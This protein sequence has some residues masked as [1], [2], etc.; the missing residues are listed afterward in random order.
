MSD[1]S[2]PVSEEMRQRVRKAAADLNYAPNPL[3]RSLKGQASH[4][5][6]VMVGNSADPYFAEITRGVEEVAGERGYLVIVCNSDRDPSRELHYLRLLHDYRADGV[7]FASSGFNDTTYTTR[8]EALV[9]QMTQRGTHVVTL[10]QSL[11]RAHSVQPDNFNGARLM[12]ADLVRMGHTR[13][14]FIGGSSNLISANMHLQGYMTAMLEAG[15]TIDPMLIL[16]GDFTQNGGKLAAQALLRLPPDQRPTAIFAAND[17]MAYG[18]LDTLREAGLRAPDD[19][20]ICGFND[21]PMSHMID[22]PLTTVRVPLRELGRAGTQL[23]L[24]L[25]NKEEQ[26]M[27]R[28]LPTE[29]IHRKSVAEV[30]GGRPF[31]AG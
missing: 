12:T 14:A 16:S 1:S 18:A 29:V 17:E 27:L 19:M 4:L 28:V 31:V 13:I 10:T 5:L 2:Y 11:L 24:A 25:L 26:P 21:L 3:A 15:R 7:L 20:S 30:P 8:V 9:H 6:A 22:P 23:L